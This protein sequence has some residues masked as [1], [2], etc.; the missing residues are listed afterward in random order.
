MSTDNQELLDGEA[1]VGNGM[2]MTQRDWAADVISLVSDATRFGSFPSNVNAF[3]LGRALGRALS[4]S[5]ES[6]DE[7]FIEAELFRGMLHYRERK[8]R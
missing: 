7:V 6:D 8:K 2:I 3:D 4:N 5:N 1:Y